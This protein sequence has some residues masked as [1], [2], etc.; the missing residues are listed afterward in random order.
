MPGSYT[1]EQDIDDT[2]LEDST[3]PPKVEVEPKVIPSGKVTDHETPA[4]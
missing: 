4:R 3:L 2:T 1:K